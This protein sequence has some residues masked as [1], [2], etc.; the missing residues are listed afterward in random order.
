LKA[1]NIKHLAV[2]YI[3]EYL[4]EY[5][6][7]PPKIISQYLFPA[8]SNPRTLRVNTTFTNGKGKRET[9]PYTYEIPG[10]YIH[11][12]NA[13]KWLNKINMQLPTD[14]RIYFHYGRHNIGIKM[15]YQSKSAIEIGDV[16]DETP[17][18][19]LEYTKHASAISSEWT[20]E[21]E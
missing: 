17:R 3:K 4:E 14:Q 15:A 6:A 2:P 7:A 9:R 13:Q 10:G 21:I 16:L 19:A 18:A 5:D 20:R 1:R 8:N 12:D 11:E